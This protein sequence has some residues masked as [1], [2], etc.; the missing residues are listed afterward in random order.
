MSAVSARPTPRLTLANRVQ[1]DGIARAWTHYRT[2]S[3]HHAWSAVDRRFHPSARNDTTAEKVE[4]DGVTIASP[5][6]ATGVHYLPT[7]WRVLDWVH[8]ALPVPPPGSTF[9]DYG[10]GKGR[11][12]LSAAEQPY[13]RVVGVEF[14]AELAALARG[15]VSDL[16]SPVAGSIDIHEG[17]AAAFAIPG[18]PVVAFL[19]NPFGPPVIERVAASLSRSWRRSPRSIIVAYLNPLHESAFAAVDGF[20]KVDLPLTSAAKI[21]LL[22]PYRLAIY[23]TPEARALMA[24]QK[25]LRRP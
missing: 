4:L 5:N 1:H 14:A 12:V 24:A 20:S 8:A 18:T 25:K 6:R 19:F 7:P 10:C 21:R 23:A 22:S 3:L 2:V 11:V 16:P 17:D 15:N 13:H 9:V